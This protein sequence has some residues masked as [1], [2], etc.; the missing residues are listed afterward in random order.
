M[1]KHVAE[2]S[3]QDNL[4]NQ[5]MFILEVQEVIFERYIAVKK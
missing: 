2:F 1:K 5:C 3:A 4:P